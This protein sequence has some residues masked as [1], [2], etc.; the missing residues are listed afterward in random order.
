MKSTT[1]TGIVSIAA[2][3]TDYVAPSTTLTIAGTANEVT[4]SAGAQDLSTNRTWTLSLPSALTF[5]GKTITGGAYASASATLF[6]FTTGSIGTA[7]TAVTQAPNTNNTTIATTAY[8][9]AIG[10]AGAPVSATYITQTPNATLSNEQA[11]SNLSTGILK[12]TTGTGV[13]SIAASNTDYLPV[14]GGTATNFTH[15]TGSLGTAVTAVTQTPGTNNTTVSTTAYADA[16]G[17][18]GA[19]VGATYITQTANATLTNEQ[20]LGSLATG[21]MKSTTGTGIVSIAA[22]GTDYVAPST[23][24]TIAGTANEITSSAG[25]QDLSTNR[26]WTLSLPASLT[27]TGKT[28]TGGSYD[29]AS[30]TN[31]TFT[32]GS[33]GTAVTAVTQA[34]TDS[35]TKIATTA[36]VS[37]FAQPGKIYPLMINQFSS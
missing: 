37:F 27:F 11:L 33:I 20:A 7:V 32:T 21:I 28:I 6:T 1:A 23:T 4:S 9:D 34:V 17:A 19:P 10:A 31:F 26:T 3:G 30:A 18:A 24:I 16:I 13:I 36:F 15:T 5:T 12:S 2:A 35:S 14:D 22:A 25:A 8:A 29:S